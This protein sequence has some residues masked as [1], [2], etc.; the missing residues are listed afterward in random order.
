M[1]DSKISNSPFK[2]FTEESLKALK[3]REA[4]LNERELHRARHAQDAHLVDGELKF[5]SKEDADILPPE[6]PDLKEGNCLLS[7]IYGRFPTRLL[8]T[9]IE[10]IDPGIR[11]KY[12][13]TSIPIANVQGL[14]TFRVL[15]ALKT[16]SIVP[17]LKTMVSALLRAFKML[18]EVILLTFFCLMVFS[19]FGL[20]IY[21]GSFRNKCV[22]NITGYNENP[23]ETCEDYFAKWIRNPENWYQEEEEYILC[24]NLTGSGMCPE[25]YICLPDIGDNPRFGYLGF[26]HFGW[27]LLTSFQLITLDFWEDIYNKAIRATGPWNVIF[28]IIVIFFGSFYL[29]NLMLAVVSMSYEEEAV[30]AGKEKEREKKEKAR[31]KHNAAYDVN[32]KKSVGRKSVMRH[33]ELGRKSGTTDNSDSTPSSTQENKSANNMVED[34]QESESKTS[35]VDPNSENV[36]T[37]GF[38]AVP[39]SHRKIFTLIFTLEATC[40]IIGLG[41]YYF[42][43]GWNVF[44]LVIAIASLLDL[45]L[46]QVDGLNVLR[47]FRLLRVFKL[48]QSWPTMRL[49]LTI[50]VST[51]GALGN[52]CLILA[53][54]IYIFA[55][56]GLQLFQTQYTEQAFGKQ[57]P[58]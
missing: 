27:A 39:V 14:R 33:F 18:F 46:E 50:I 23:S 22:K 5:G 36:T 26:D 29:I 51:L 37:T 53:I 17:G 24:G 7:S 10:E 31:K 43:V 16:V 9:P 40:K 38:M 42:V 49:L 4:L 11:E 52:L 32:P 56:I 6:N 8:G 47:T 48:A 44:D 55:V 57:L 2:P 1:E 13:A 34:V 54:V 12:S 45:S 20:Q 41:K 19:M 28:F 25:N 30:S 35:A 58:R 21:M 15:R 3:E